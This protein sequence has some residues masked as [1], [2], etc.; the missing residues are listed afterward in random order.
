M[1]SAL[2]R[3]AGR[4]H[5]ARTRA[6]S[7]DKLEALGHSPAASEH[8]LPVETALDDIPA[9]AVTETEAARLRHGQ[10]VP[11]ATPA[12]VPPL[13]RRCAV[14]PTAGSKLVASCRSMARLF[15]PVRVF[16]L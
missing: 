12:H 4:A 6:I 7:L 13:R 3:T 14:A 16:N 8:L 9:L 15:R 11:L 5:S 10:P 2:R 1:S